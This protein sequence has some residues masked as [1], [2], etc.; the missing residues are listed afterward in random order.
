MRGLSKS[1]VLVLVA[2]VAMP[3]SICKFAPASMIIKNN[4][5][6]AATGVFT[7][8]V[9]LDSTTDIQLGDGFVI[10][11]FL[12]YV[13]NSATLT[14]L[15]GGGSLSLSRFTITGISS[16][17]SP[18]SDPNQGSALNNPVA[19]N[20]LAQTEADV[21]SLPMIYA[22]PNSPADG[23]SNPTFDN[24]ATPNLSFVYNS[25][26]TYATSGPETYLLSL[27]TSAVN[28]NS[29]VSNTV[30]TT[31]D[32]NP[33]DFNTLAYAE[34]L[35]YVPS[36]GNSTQITLPEP[37]MLGVIALGSLGLRRRRAH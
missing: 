33:A 23:L 8:T 11:D 30:V 14:P 27:S 24:S 4:T 12:D 31:E 29:A 37:T 5:V 26:S 18:N 13:P 1:R 19:I 22:D 34:N 20:Q 10:Y 17:D 32:H 6:N 15:T 36:G 3:L 35:L 28:S 9:T 7:Y 21:T 2:A 16:V 25:S